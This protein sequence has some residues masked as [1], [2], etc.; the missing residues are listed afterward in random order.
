MPHSFYKLK[1]RQVRTASANHRNTVNAWIQL[2]TY[3][4]TQRQPWGESP[5]MAKGCWKGQ[6]NADSV[7]ILLNCPRRDLSMRKKKGHAGKLPFVL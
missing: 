3:F 1:H 7:C 5:V 2:D 6:K 4:P